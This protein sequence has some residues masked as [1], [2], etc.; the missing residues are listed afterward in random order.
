MDRKAYLLVFD[1]LAD[2]EPAL[3]LC[4]IRKS[5]RFQVVTAGF[6]AAP[7]TTMGGLK[8]SADVSLEAVRADEAAIFILPGGT[9]WE[10]NPPAGIAGFLRQLNA[11][12]VPI[13][14]ICG[15]TLAIARAGLIAQRRHTSNAPE[16]LRAFIPDYSAAANY[17]DQLAVCDDRIITASGVGSVEFAYEII[18]LLALYDERDGRDWFNLFKHAKM[19]ASSGRSET[20]EK[21]G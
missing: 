10:E 20:G 7:V 16:Y 15:A 11:A 8:V 2:W 12:A 14:A 21:H 18:K 6:S 19:P 9:M 1:G 17:V 3:A 4:E 5:N 13:A